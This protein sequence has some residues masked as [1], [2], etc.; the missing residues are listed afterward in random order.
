MCSGDGAVRAALGRVGDLLGEFWARKQG[1]LQPPA[2]RERG[3]PESRVYP[4][5]QPRPAGTP[6]EAHLFGP[7]QVHVDELPGT[8]EAH[9]HR[10]IVFVWQNEEVG[11]T[12]Q[13]RTKTLWLGEG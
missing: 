6:W 13:R 9:W 12:G 2:Q 4:R 1:T 7:R 10:L 5:C 8:K 11:V 3:I